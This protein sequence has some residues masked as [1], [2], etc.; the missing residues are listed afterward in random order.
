MKCLIQAMENQIRYAD[1]PRYK[2]LYSKTFRRDGATSISPCLDSFTVLLVGT[3]RPYIVIIHDDA[4]RVTDLIIGGD[5][6][7]QAHCK[8]GQS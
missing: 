2:Q 4:S 7:V 6:L 5:D 8:P 1:N 3:N